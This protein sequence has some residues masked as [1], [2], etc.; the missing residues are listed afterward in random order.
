MLKQLVIKISI[1]LG[2]LLTAG[3]GLAQTEYEYIDI[4]NPFLRKIPLAVPWFKM[5]SGHAVEQEQSRKAAELMS[6]TLEFTGY[7]KIIDRG[8]FLADP[9]NPEI[10]AA[11][12]RFRNWTGI[13][14]ELLITG[15]ILVDGRHC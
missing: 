7:F 4:S 13:G 3:T 8:A 15:G 12:I 2:L 5:T 14:A 6:E 9:L 11:N 10:V 1:V